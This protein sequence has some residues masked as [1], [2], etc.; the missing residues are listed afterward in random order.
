[1]FEIIVRTNSQTKILNDVNG[2]YFILK[3]LKYWVLP[4]I[5]YDQIYNNFKKKNFDHNKKLKTKDFLT[6]SKKSLK[7]GFWRK[8]YKDK[9]KFFKK[10]R[11]FLMVNN[12]YKKN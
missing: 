1:M 7:Q 10:Q 3:L 8:K 5:F 12:F 9:I 6:G 2:N 4:V 11:N